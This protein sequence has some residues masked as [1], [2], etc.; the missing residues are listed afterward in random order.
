VSTS[1]RNAVMK[2]RATAFNVIVTDQLRIEDGTRAE[3]AGY[4]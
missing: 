3:T 2:A 4:N 1:T